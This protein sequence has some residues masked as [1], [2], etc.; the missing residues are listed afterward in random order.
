MLWQKA[1]RVLIMK[2][3]FRR[4]NT[5]PCINHLG[6]DAYKRNGFISIDDEHESVSKTLEYAYD[7][8]CI[9]QMANITGHAADYD[10]F[11]KRSQNW[12]ANLTYYKTHAPET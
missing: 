5:A 6:L 1:L 11:M 3:H 10:Y 9:A 12:K 2:R 4:Q 8:W 7:D